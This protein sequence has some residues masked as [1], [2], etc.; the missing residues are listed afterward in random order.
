MPKIS[1]SDKAAKLGGWKDKWNKLP[2]SSITGS[3]QLDELRFA[4]QGY[5]LD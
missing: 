1:L 3:Q 5:Q 2:D 4:F